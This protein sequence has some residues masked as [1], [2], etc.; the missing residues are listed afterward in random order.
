MR[1]PLTEAEVDRLAMRLGV[2]AMVAG[3]LWLL[4][5]WAWA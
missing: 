5:L 1:R 2:W 4:A 3:S